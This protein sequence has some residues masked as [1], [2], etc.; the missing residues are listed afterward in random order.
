M[1]IC[2]VTGTR[3]EYGFL[4]WLLKELEPELQLIVTG[5]HLSPEFG[6]TVKEIDFPIAAKVEMLLSSD[7]GVGTAK[8]MGLAT[9]G[10]A[11]AFDRLK[12]DIIVLTGDRFETLA[13]AQAALVMRIPV[14]HIAGGDITEGAFDDAIRH[15]ITKMAHLHFVTNEEAEDV[16]MQLGEDATYVYNVGSPGLDGIKRMRFMDRAEVEE[17]LGITLRDNNLLIVFHPSTWDGYPARQFQELL[18]ALE[19]MDAGKIFI[20]P[21]A[22]P[23]SRQIANMIPAGASFA[24]LPRELYLNVI[25]QVDA[26]VGNSSSGVMEVPSFKKPTINIG[27]RQLGRIMA[28]SVIPCQPQAAEIRRAIIRAMNM[29][30]AGVINYYGDGESSARIAQL[31]RTVR[32]QIKKEFY[33]C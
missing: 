3:A 33:R 9:I 28:E 17:K 18:L 14:A 10:F 2:V 13:A 31:L 6:L 19:G 23:G 1:K 12:P 20:F 4:Y 24:S 16:V 21:N 29:N 8:S 32:P 5:A 27:S 22:D 7:T 25:N 26:V 30:C 11:D 15:A